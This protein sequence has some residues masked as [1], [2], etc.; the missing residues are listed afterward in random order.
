ME[1]FIVAEITK[2]WIYE[3]P[4]AG[5]I[6]NLFEGVINR[7]YERGYKLH[8]WRLNQ[9]YTNDGYTFTETIIAVFEKIDSHAKEKTTKERKKTEVQ[10]D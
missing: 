9:V 8:D 10:V 2:N 1:K 3:T 7:N 4:V 5:L 6:S